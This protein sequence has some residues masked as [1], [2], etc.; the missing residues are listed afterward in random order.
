MKS[1]NASSPGEGVLA[2]F[3]NSLLHKKS[4]QSP[5]LTKTTGKQALIYLFIHTQTFLCLVNFY[6]YVVCLTQISILYSV[7]CVLINIL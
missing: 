3:F 6:I 1:T 7:T 5:A 4:N 2:N